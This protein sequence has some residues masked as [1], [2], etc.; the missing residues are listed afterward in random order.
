MPVGVDGAELLGKPLGK[1]AAPPLLAPPEIDEL[2]VLR[3][4][5]GMIGVDQLVQI[6]CMLCLE[7]GHRHLLLAD[8][9]HVGRHLLEYLFVLQRV[10]ILQT[11]DLS[12]F[13]P[14]NIPEEQAA[15]DDLVDGLIEGYRDPLHFTA[16]AGPLQDLAHPVRIVRALVPRLPLRADGAIGPGH[17]PEIGIHREMG[18]QGERV[19]RIAVDLDRDPV[20]DFYLYAAPRVAVEAHGVQG[21]FSFH[22]FIGF[23]GGYFPRFNASQQVPGKFQL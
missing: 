9:R 20:H 3:P 8:R 4:E 5:V 1:I 13:L 2:V 17:F 14:G 23:E 15:V 6:R 11:G 22:E 16:S 12:V 7:V 19:V 10:Y 21:V 18:M